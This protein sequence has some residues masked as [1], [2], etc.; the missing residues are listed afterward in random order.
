MDQ[1]ISQ[2]VNECTFKPQ[3]F[4]SK[5]YENVDSTYQFASQKDSEEFSRKLKE[6]LQ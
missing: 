4:K 3:T 6:K 1:Y 2:E 5:K